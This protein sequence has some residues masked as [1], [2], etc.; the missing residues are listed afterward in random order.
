MTMPQ[1]FRLRSPGA[2]WALWAKE[3]SQHA[4]AVATLTIFFALIGLV[5]WF[6]F[7]KATRSISVLEIVPRLAMSA[8]PAAA[9]VLGHRLVVAEYYGRTQR[10]LE[11]LPLR[12]G[13][14][15][16]VKLLFGF[17]WLA[18]WGLATLVAALA[19]AAKTEPIEP[20]FAG[21]LAVRLLAYTAA[22]WAAVFLFNVF[23]RLRLPLLVLAGFVLVLLTNAGGVDLQERGP[24]ALVDP[25]TYVVERN[26]LP[27]A[28]LVGALLVTSACVALALLL[29]SLREGGIVE[30]L[31]KPLSTR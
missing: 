9:L 3:W 25:A 18:L 21:L 10:F 6:S 17:F 23:G 13:Q 31:A 7:L 11:A 24:L 16:A 15:A 14:E 8:L 2:L 22:L 26:Q 19:L 5:A 12:R 29:V 1:R 28:A 30:M 27:R 20:R 4:R